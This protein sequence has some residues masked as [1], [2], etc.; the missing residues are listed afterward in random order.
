MNRADRKRI[1]SHIW[2]LTRKQR[3]FDHVWATMRW[4]I[5][6][7]HLTVDQVLAMDAEQL[8]AETERLNS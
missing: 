3:A 6:Q 2:H 4:A 5:E 8:R 7:A 1:M